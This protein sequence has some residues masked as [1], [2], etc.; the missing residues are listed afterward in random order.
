MLLIRSALWLSRRGEN[1]SVISEDRTSQSE[2]ASGEA[3][4]PKEALAGIY[5]REEVTGQKKLGFESSPPTLGQRGQ[6]A[7]T[8]RASGTF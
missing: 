1:E 7:E 8:P 2:A 4:A 3:E 6:T 5:H